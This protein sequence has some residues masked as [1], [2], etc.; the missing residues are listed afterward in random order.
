ME[1]VQ[2]LIGENL[3]RLRDLVPPNAPLGLMGHS[4]GG[5]FVLHFLGS[6]AF[7]VEF[8][9]VSSSLVDPRGR[10]GRWKVA[11]AR[12]LGAMWPALTVRSGVRSEDCKR[13]LERIEATRC[14]P[15]VHRKISLGLGGILLRE[16]LRLE[17]LAARIPDSLSLLMTHGGEDRLCPVENAR[18]LFEQIP[19]RR[20]EFLLFPDQ[21]HEP[22]NDL[23]RDEFYR[24]LS[25]WIGETLEG[26]REGCRGLPPVAA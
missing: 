22:F 9:W 3:R 14:D 21:L 12:L 8:A 15:L 25:D 16:S 2:T 24:G 5:F 17:A 26:L 4:M 11:A 13:D 6:R 19:A 1:T 20:K 18:T 23:G 10:A 7:P